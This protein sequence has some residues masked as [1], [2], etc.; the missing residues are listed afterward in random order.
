MT[1][2]LGDIQFSLLFKVYKSVLLYAEKRDLLIYPNE[3]ETV[4]T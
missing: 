4:K 1:R 2:N 3:L